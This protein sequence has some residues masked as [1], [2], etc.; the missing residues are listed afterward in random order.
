MGPSFNIQVV[1]SLGY[2]GTMDMLSSKQETCGSIE[3]C[4]GKKDGYGD[5]ANIYMVSVKGY[6]VFPRRC[7]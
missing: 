4:G 2:V 1:R 5:L 7:G 6:K 3:V